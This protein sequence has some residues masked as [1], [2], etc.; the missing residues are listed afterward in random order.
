MWSGKFNA[1]WSLFSYSKIF[2]FFAKYAHLKADLYFVFHSLF[3]N[4]G[5]F[6]QRFQVFCNRAEKEDDKNYFLYCSK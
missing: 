4:K 3:Q 1:K 6:L 5:L 2:F